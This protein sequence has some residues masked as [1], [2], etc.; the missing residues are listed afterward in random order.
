MGLPARCRRL[1]HERRLASATCRRSPWPASSARRIGATVAVR[2]HGARL[3][4]QLAAPAR[5]APTRSWCPPAPTAAS[6]ARRS[7]RRSVTAPTSG[8]VIAAGG[9]H[10]RRRGRRP[11][12][13]GRRGRAA[14]RLVARRR[15]VRRRRRCC[16]PSGATLF[17]GIERA[18]SV[19][20]DPH[21]WLFAPEGSCALLYREPALAAA[22]HT[23][24]GPYID[25]PRTATSRCGTRATTATSSPG[26]PPACRC[27][28]RSPCTASTPTSRRSVRG[29]ELAELRRRR[30][31]PRLPGVAL[32]MQPQLGVVLFRREGWGRAEWQAVGRPRAAPTASR[33]WRLA[34]GRAS[35]WAGWCSCTRARP[36]RSSTRS[37]P[38]SATEPRA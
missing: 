1:L 23:Q 2:R 32:V 12:R 17:D 31:S 6:P 29:V 10:Q 7:P 18:D 35:R 8:I 27:G 15:R 37:S 13:A 38:R 9:L 14:R 36:T 24:H 34:P 21:K 3:G 20:V 16:C 30:G 4:V 28:S 22:V 11:R 26:G 33:S 25:V 19:I 5:P